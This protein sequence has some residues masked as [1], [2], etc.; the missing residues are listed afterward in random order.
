MSNSLF[1][2]FEFSEVTEEKVKLVCC[3]TITE[4]GET[5]EWW[6]HKNAEKQNELKKYL[7]K[8]DL[9]V[10][11][12]AIAEARSF[13][14]LGLNP[15]SYEWIDLF[16]E[17]R[18][19]T[20][21]NDELAY[22]EQLVDGKVSHKFKPKPKWERT[23]EDSKTGFKPTHSL[24]EASFKLLGI[25][26][27]TEHKEAMRKLII[28]NPESYTKEQQAAIMAYCTE[29]VKDLKPMFLKMK[30]KYK[31]LDYKIEGEETLISEMKLR[32]RFSA[33]TAI[34]ESK[35]YPIDIKKT[36]NFS[37]HVGNILFDCQRE[38]NNLFPEIK[39]FRW[40][41][42]NQKYTWD[43]NATRDWVEKN[44]DVNGWV[45]TDTG[46]ISLALEAFTRFYDFK[47]DYPTDNFG[48]QM[49]RY[50]KLKQ[51]LYGFVP[52]PDKEK[53]TFW[54]S[55]G[56][57]GRVR[58]Y[59]N[60][61]GAQSSRSQ[62]SSTGF[63]F[64]KPAWMRALVQPAEGKA[65]AGIDY[66][67]QEFFLSA[68]LSS[69]DEMIDAY[70]SGDPYFAFAKK[71]GAV[72]ADAKKEDYKTVRDLFKATVLGISYLMT[73]YGLAIKLTSDTGQ[74]W[75]EDGAQ[76][77]IDLF[78][79]TFPCLKE[80]QNWL[81]DIY[82]ED[83]YL[84][85][86]CLAKGT[87]IHT[88]SGRKKI[89]D[90]SS[91][92]EIWDGAKWV[93]SEGTVSRGEKD[94]ILIE[95]ENILAT[96]NHLFLINNCW[97]TAV[98]LRERDFQYRNREPV[99]GD[100]RLLALKE[101][102]AKPGLSY[103]AAYVELKERLG[104]GICTMEMLKP[105]LDALNL[106]VPKDQTGPTASAKFL[107]TNIFGK[108]GGPVITMQKKG[109]K[110]PLTRN[111]RGMVLEAFNSASN[112]LEISWNILL[113]SMA[114]DSGMEH[115]IELITT[116]LICPET[117]ELLANWRT[118]KT[119]VF[120][121][122]NC[123][124]DNRYQS[125]YLISHNCG[126]YMWGDNPNFRSASNMPIQGFGASVLRKAVDL[127]FERGLYVP[128]TLHDAVYIEYNVGE[129]YKIKILADCMREAFVHYL[130]EDKKEFG[131]KI[132]LDPFA[133]SPNYEKDSE[134]EVEGMKIPISNL[135]IDSRSEK[136]Y[137]AFSKYFEDES[138]DLL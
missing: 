96:P 27:D 12:A 19:L 114:I 121:L 86:P 3:T 135:Y 22:G 20:N 18:C 104:S 65:M 78:Y 116:N 87:W 48:A 16:L 110:I 132:K 31:E 8:F 84:K 61:Y 106:S 94:V 42:K 21:H 6:L 75:T 5:I 134:I 101:N 24:A 7:K 130:E 92:D 32:G 49:V 14:S 128:F 90:I 118:I 51:T 133:W 60:I 57:D 91:E 109:V 17:Y 54:H 129:E 2:D 41:K 115:S 53:K 117:Y 11:Y 56:S 62:P 59:T 88:K 71:S 123:G 40:N 46:N 52:S 69:D 1:L 120:D 64:L 9:H 70:L 131:S 67:S 34:M 83:K 30:E 39:P 44:H 4:D 95:G 28:S 93:K 119:E 127:A 68:L 33:L 10:S 122:I 89:E 23:E 72:P 136:D 73:K 38:I 102:V 112:P 74:V 55:V 82:K 58:P 85:L 108:N 15:L 137:L 124:P 25:I 47:H 100:G 45:K 37:K 138:G 98:E 105:V 63:M 13:Y 97:M 111:S 26:R 81:L 80:Y 50:L 103:A 66:G 29:D 79:S 77:Q 99:S 107:M 43:Q 125:Q 36:K 113:R 126:W 35:G 76:D